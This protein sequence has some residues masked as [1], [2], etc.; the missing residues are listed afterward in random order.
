MEILQ[1]MV[2]FAEINQALLPQLN[3]AAYWKSSNTKASANTLSQIQQ[4]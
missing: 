1:W 3:V 2:H 4:W